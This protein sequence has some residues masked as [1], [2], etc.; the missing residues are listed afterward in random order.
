MKPIVN[1]DVKMPKKMLRALTL[2]EAYCV[3]NVK[4]ETNELEVK[5]FL[6]KHFDKNMADNF[7]SQYLY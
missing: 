4:K 1:T 5:D 6:S 2:F 7:K 3:G